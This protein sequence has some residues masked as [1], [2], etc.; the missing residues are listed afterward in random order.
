METELTFRTKTK[1]MLKDK[2][3]IF[4]IVVFATVSFGW[5]DRISIKKIPHDGERRNDE[6]LRVN[7][8]SF[9]CRRSLL[10]RFI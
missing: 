5:L 10:G 6:K 9:L 3:L 2:R 8:I 4:A 1:R 7:F